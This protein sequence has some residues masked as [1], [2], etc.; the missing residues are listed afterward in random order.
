MTMQIDIVP[1]ERD[2]LGEGPVWDPRLQVLYWSDQLGKR[3]R[4]LAPATGEYREWTVDK[5]LGCIALTQDVNAVVIALADGFYR[6][7]LVSGEC[8]QLMEVPQPRPGVRLNDGRCDRSGRL[9]AGSV[10]TDGGEGAGKIYRF[11]PDGRLEVLR[12]EMVI[13]NAICC[14]PAGDRIYYTDSRGGILYARDYDRDGDHIG[15]ER[16][17]VDI[18]PHGGAPDGATVDA[19]GGIWVAQIMLGNIL[20]FHSDGT[21]D[22][23]I[24]MPAPHVSSLAFGGAELDTLYVTTVRET[25]MRISTDHPKAGAL[26][27]ITGLGVRGCEEGIFGARTNA[28]APLE[29]VSGEKE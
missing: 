9:I 29:N 15:E 16:E 17:F 2:L 25:G 13:A 11:S 22:R 18:R 6:L 3:V 27:A 24:E 20:R 19:E 1:V 12:E 26:F 5:P 8:A 14:S 23:K 28:A 21:L 7:D 10:T 4:R